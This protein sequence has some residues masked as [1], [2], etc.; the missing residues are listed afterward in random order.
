LGVIL[1]ERAGQCAL[2]EGSVLAHARHPEGAKRLR[3]CVKTPNR[4]FVGCISTSSASRKVR[5]SFRSVQR[6]AYTS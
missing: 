6:A 4:R 5:G 2:P 3:D 1:K